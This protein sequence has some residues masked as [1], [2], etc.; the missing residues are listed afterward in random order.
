MFR[1][2]ISIVRMVVL[3]A[4]LTSGAAFGGDAVGK[5]YRCT[6]KDA[7]SLE[8]NGTLD[9]NPIGDARRKYF[10][11]MVINV[12]NGEVAYPSGGQREKRAVQVT[13]VVG[14]ADARDY[15]LIPDTAFQRKKAVAKAL[16]DFIR[17]RVQAREPQVTFAAFSL[18][19]LVT[20][21]CE[22]AR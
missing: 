7:I 4:I 19:Q 8:D 21:T 15:V 1:Q 11:G 12:L 17:L 3:F 13:D 16:T 20:G 6:A 10:D 14:E 5:T 22:L 9:K 18:S 2:L